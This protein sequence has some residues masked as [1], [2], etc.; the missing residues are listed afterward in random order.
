MTMALLQ[1]PNK[2]REALDGTAICSSLKT[3]AFGDF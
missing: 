2:G 1:N 3:E